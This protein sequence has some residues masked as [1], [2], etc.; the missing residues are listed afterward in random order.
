MAKQ[1]L[2]VTVF[3]RGL[4]PSREKAQALIMAGQIYLNGQKVSKAGASVKP[5]DQ[6]ELHG[7]QLPFVSRGGLK[8]NKAMQCFPIT[9][10]QKICMDVGAST[11]GFTDCMLQ[12]GARKVYAIDVGYGQLAWKLRLSLI[13]I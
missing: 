12:N 4:A 2:D 13:H 7:T 1:R 6:I 8:L 11:G 5:E 10:E 9:L 3:E